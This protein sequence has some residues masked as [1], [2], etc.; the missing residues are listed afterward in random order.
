MAEALTFPELAQ[1]RQVLA[2]ARELHL[3]EL[4]PR[5]CRFALRCAEC[6]QAVSEQ[7]LTLIRKLLKFA[8]GLEDG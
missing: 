8:S 3:T 1:V 7:H 6:N 2:D 4:E 5:V